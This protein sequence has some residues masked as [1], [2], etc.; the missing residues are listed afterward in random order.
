MSIRAATLALCALIVLLPAPR[1]VLADTG[2]LTVVGSASLGD[3]GMNAALAIA[4]HCAWVGSRNDA[5]VQVVDISDPTSPRRVGALPGRSGSTPR[6]V[7]ADP[8]AH[9]LVVLYYRLGSLGPNRLD[10][11]RWG[12]DCGAAAMVGGYDFG[13]ASPHEFF[14]WRDPA[15]AGRTLLYTTMFA[16]ASEAL[17]V[18]DISDPA[19]PRRLGGWVVPAGYGNAPLHSI[20]LSADGG[21]AILSLWT[22]GLVVADVSAFAAGSPAPVLRL[23]TPPGAAF[24]TAPGNVHSVVPL[25]S[26]SRVLT[27]DERYPAPFGPGCPSGV[28]HVVDVQDPARPIALSTLSVPENAPAACARDPRQ[29]WSSH[30]A[31]VLADLAF[32]TWYS[33]G[34]EVFSLDDPVTPLR[35]AELRPAGGHPAQR[36]LQ[37]GTTDTLAWSY[38]VIDGGLVYVVDI[39][40]GLLVLRYTG[41]HSDEVAQVAFREGNSNVG[42][43]PATSPAASAPATT[44]PTASPSGRAPGPGSLPRAPG[45]GTLS[46]VLL[47]VVAIVLTA[48]A[49]GGTA[50]ARRR[51]G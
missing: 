5:P 45:P 7:R 16:S 41:P 15:R 43:G 22:G 28:A 35:V 4:S 37:L 29:T 11:Y 19:V 18:I 47:L 42:V 9:V 23:L 12:A 32:I 38:P 13:G 44:L 21:T 24:R 1:T 10:I 48:A 30:N 2:A 40:Q 46:E 49:V 33:A 50:L 39:N 8:D 36:D 27:T 20:A 3:R 6:E 25:A 51:R 17:E 34:V 26:G 31:T 14:L